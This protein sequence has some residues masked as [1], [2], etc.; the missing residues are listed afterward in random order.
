[1]IKTECALEDELPLDRRRTSTGGTAKHGRRPQQNADDDPRWLQVLRDYMLASARLVAA[2][3]ALVDTRPTTTAGV[4]ALATYAVAYV[5]SGEIWKGGA[6]M[7]T[8]RHILETC[9]RLLSRPLRYTATPLWRRLPM[10]RATGDLKAAVVG[11]TST[12]ANAYMAGP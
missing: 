9:H 3:E 1:M 11:A 4:I 6:A 12:A 10:A 5:R 8:R 2:A 7:T